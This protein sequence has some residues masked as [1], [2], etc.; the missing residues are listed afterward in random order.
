MSP[1]PAFTAPWPPGAF[2]SGPGRS[3]SPS[4]LP[5]GEDGGEKDGGQ[6]LSSEAGGGLHTAEAAYWDS[7][8]IR[9]YLVDAEYSDFRGPLFMARP[10]GAAPVPLCLLLV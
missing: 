9:S 10:G 6:Q 7:A 1:P 5:P 4:S 3:R 8:V 2:L